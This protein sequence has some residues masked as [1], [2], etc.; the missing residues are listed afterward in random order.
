M[1]MHPG[2]SLTAQTSLHIVLRLMLFGDRV[3]TT[4]RLWTS[5]LMWQTVL[6]TMWPVSPA[7][8]LQQQLSLQLRTPSMGFSR[9]CTHSSLDL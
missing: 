9:Y 1:S 3:V 7:G 2:L 6:A 8:A 5:L 4:L